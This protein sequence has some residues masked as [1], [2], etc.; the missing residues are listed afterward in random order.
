M[1]I[2]IKR[3]LNKEDISAL[4]GKLSHKS[5]FDVKKFCGVLTLKNP[6]LTIQKK[7][8]DEWA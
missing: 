3:S 4:L 8:R 6:P 5:K 1:T 2:V 7:L